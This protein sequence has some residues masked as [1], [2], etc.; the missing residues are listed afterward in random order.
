MK[1]LGQRGF[2]SLEILNFLKLTILLP[3][4]R[5][6]IQPIARALILLRAGHFPPL[7]FQVHLRQW[8]SRADRD[9]SLTLNMNIR[10][11]HCFGALEA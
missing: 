1:F 6:G 10:P 8:R 5:R 3:R 2:D 4:R 11:F 7:E 9:S